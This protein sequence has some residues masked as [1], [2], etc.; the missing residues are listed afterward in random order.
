MPGS[1]AAPHE[2]LGYEIIFVLS[3]SFK[4]EYGEYSAGSL[5][6][7]PSGSQHAW[8]S[9][10]GATLFVVWEKPTKLIK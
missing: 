5:A 2:H 3:G 8:T 10:V 7:F 9:E 6:I 1:K 4:D